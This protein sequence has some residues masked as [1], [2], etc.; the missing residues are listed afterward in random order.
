M[1]EMARRPARHGSALARTALPAAVTGGLTYLIAYLVGVDLATCFLLAVVVG[2]IALLAG[3]LLDLEQRL[4]TIERLE[5]DGV[6]GVRRLIGD[7]FTDISEATTL[8]GQIEASGLRT[9]LVA[10]LVRNAAAFTSDSPPIVHQFAQAK[11]KET[12]DLLKQL[13]EGGTVT[14]YGEDRD[15]LLGL[16]QQAAASIDGITLAAV[17]HGLWYSELGQRYLDAQR[18]AVMAGR[19]VRRIFVLDGTMMELDSELRQAYEDQ[20]QMGIEVRLLDRSAIPI[21]LRVQVRDLIVF[22][23]ILAYETTPTTADPHL[24]QVAETRLVLTAE[25]VT[26]AVQLFAELWEVA[27]ELAPAPEVPVDVYLDTEDETESDQVFKVVDDLAVWLG[28]RTPVEVERHPGSIFRRAKTRVA[29]DLL[30]TQMQDRVVRLERALQL[31][32]DNDLRAGA[33]GDGY[34]TQAAIALI[35][36]LS[37]IPHACVRLGRVLLVK[38]TG[39]SGAVLVVRD[40]TLPEMEVLEQHPH[41]QTSPQTI[42]AELDRAV[43]DRRIPHAREGS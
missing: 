43:R 29:T 19:R 39:A 35:E 17:D 4:N 15:W 36:A 11:L 8:F 5:Q 9:D 33:A 27:R 16:T 3:F 6:A 14:Y 37:T 34:E 13:A 28:H 22:D 40:L 42:L 1:G 21:P 10:Q 30:Q 12:A 31:V 26:D 32:R 25:R 23:D 18:R 2:G 41:L 20:R 38:Y 7:T 24:A